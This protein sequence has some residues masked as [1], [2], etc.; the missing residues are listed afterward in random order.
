MWYLKK[1]KI[2]ACSKSS[3]VCESLKKF[4]N[5]NISLFDFNEKFCVLKGR[6]R[7]RSDL[8]LK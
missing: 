6:K 2:I 4:T 5:E 8:N 1:E 7:G 3:H